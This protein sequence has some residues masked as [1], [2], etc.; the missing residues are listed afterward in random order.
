[1]SQL[2]SRTNIENDD[3]ICPIT[4][5]LFRDPVL[6]GDGRV[7][8]REAITKWILER[9]TSPIT[10]EPLQINHLQ[11]DDHLRRLANQQQNSRVSC[12]VRNESVT[13]PLLLEVPK[14]NTQ[15]V[16]ELTIHPN[17]IRMNVLS[18][19][20]SAF[21]IICFMIFCV[22][23]AAG[24]TSVILIVRMKSSKSYSTSTGNIKFL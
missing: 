23:I 6:A 13:F 22:G 19:R 14:N 21:Q 20:P 4:R 24:A 5:E 3:L 17:R 1:M 10:R 15:P 11:S 18:N 7:Y 16:P 2:T 12:N 9:G 8:E